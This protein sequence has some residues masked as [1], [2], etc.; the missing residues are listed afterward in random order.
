MKFVKGDTIDLEITANVDI[1]GWK[2]RVEF[3]DKSGHSVQLATQ[4]AGGSDSQVLI[5]DA[6]NG[7]FTITATA[8]GTT[9]FDDD[10]FI[11]IER[12]DT[13]SKR[14]TILQKPIEMLAEQITWS[15]PSS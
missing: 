13:N 8:G 7:V 3:Y 15:T 5:T 14:L 6:S 9:D 10:A 4:N 1:T 2:I 12:E 11:E